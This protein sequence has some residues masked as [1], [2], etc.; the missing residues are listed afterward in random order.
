ML[1][2]AGAFL[3]SSLPD[4]I[5]RS[6]RRL[7]LPSVAAS[8]SAAAFRYGPRGHGRAKRR[9]FFERLPSGDDW[10]GTRSA[11]KA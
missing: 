2:L 9:R 1:A 6:M 11:D 10:K 8:F 7:G 3:L 5:R 4:L